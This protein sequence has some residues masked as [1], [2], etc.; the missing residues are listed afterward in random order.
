MN[1]GPKANTIEAARL[2]KASQMGDRGAFD[3]LVRLYQKRAMLVAVRILGGADEAAEAVQMGFLK[4]Y[5]N[6]KKLRDAEQFEC[7]LLRIVANAAISQARTA[8]RRAAQVRIAD[9]SQDNAALSAPQEQAAEDL[10][11]AIGQAMLR[12]SKREAQA[13]SLFGLQD[14][15]QKEVARIMRCSVEAVRWHVFNARKKLKVLL[16]EYLE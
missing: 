10:S 14:M 12:L 8:K 3:E 6:I 4:A 5:L 9:C 7:W 2:V 13:I 1:H 15:S 11:R 16:K